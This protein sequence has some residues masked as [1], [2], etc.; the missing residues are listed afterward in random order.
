[1]LLDNVN[2]EG[3]KCTISNKIFGKPRS[4]RTLGIRQKETMGRPEFRFV[5]G[6]F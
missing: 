2:S 1:M 6:S 5:H 3:P 4:L